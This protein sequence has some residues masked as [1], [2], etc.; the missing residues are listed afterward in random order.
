MARRLLVAAGAVAR[1]AA[2]PPRR[3]TGS[4]RLERFRG[5]AV[6]HRPAAPASYRDRAHPGATHADRRARRPRRRQQISVR[7]TGGGLRF[8]LRLLAGRFWLLVV[9]AGGLRHQEGD[10]S[11]SECVVSVSSVLE[12]GAS[13]KRPP[14]KRGGT[15]PGAAA[16]AIHHATTFMRICSELRKQERRVRALGNEREGGRRRVEGWQIAV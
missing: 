3:E 15:K 7:S 1:D 12:A 9:A 14:T 5:S 13:W 2:R 16:E 4:C 6:D 10:R 11:R 8:S